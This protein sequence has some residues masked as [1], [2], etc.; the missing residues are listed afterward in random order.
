M[1]A[2]VVCAP[3][4]SHAGNVK[5]KLREMLVDR[6]GAHGVE[7]SPQ[8]EISVAALYYMTLRF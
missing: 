1:H 3:S 4:Q 7:P 6:R 5:Q 2:C 8:V